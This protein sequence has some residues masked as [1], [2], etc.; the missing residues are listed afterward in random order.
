[1][2]K[3]LWWSVGA[4]VLAVGMQTVAQQKMLAPTPPMGWNSWDSY[5]LTVNESQFRANVD[6]LTKRLKPARR[7]SI[8]SMRMDAMSLRSTALPR[9]R[10]LPDSNRWPTTSTRRD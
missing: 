3:G 5:G 4:A 7:C 8:V 2:L 9:R 10:E 6:A 1:M